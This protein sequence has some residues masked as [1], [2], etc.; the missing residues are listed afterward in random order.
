M[1][2]SSFLF[3]C[4]LGAVVSACSSEESDNGAQPT[5]DT[6]SSTEQDSSGGTTPGEDA[7]TTPEVCVYPPS[8]GRVEFGGVV[9]DMSWDVAY[10]GDELVEE[11][12]DLYEFHCSD[13]FDQYDTLIFVVTTVWCPYCPGMMEYIDRLGEQLEE[14]GA[15]VV[16]AEVQNASGGPINTEGAQ[17]HIS[18][19]V[20]RSQGY[21]VGDADN[22]D[23]NALGSQRIIQ[24]FPTTLVVRRDDMTVIADSSRS[25]YYLPFVEI[26]MDPEADWSSPGPPTIVP[27][28]ELACGPED[29]EAS[30]GDNNRPDTAPVLAP[31]DEIDGGVC[32]AN[33]DY[34]KIEEAGEWTARLE[35]THADGD[36]D[37]YV[38]D[39]ENDRPLADESGTAIGSDTTN[40]VEEFSYS[41]PATLMVYGYRNASGVYNLTLSAP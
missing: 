23:P 4:L 21:R 33:P 40:D 36:L 20:T 41:G 31:G 19:Y 7:S 30:E 29:E 11:G 32:D 18:D 38:W 13:A 28:L 37:M 14:E 34:Y 12:F 2:R 22:Y 6:G 39:V 8:N 1:K 35:F 27:E 5:P 10:L 26:A 15:L 3:A 17:N 16:F 9:P 24:A 25:N